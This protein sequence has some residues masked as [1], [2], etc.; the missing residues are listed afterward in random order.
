MEQADIHI[1][2]HYEYRD[3]PGDEG[4]QQVKVLEKVRSKWRVEWLDPNPGLVDYVKSAN[5]VVAWKDRGPFLGDEKR[6]RELQAACGRTWPG[7]DHPVS[8]AVDEVL[9]ATGEDLWVDNRGAFSG[10]PD[11]F[12]R[13]CVRARFTLPDEHVA[14]TDRRGMRHHTFDTALAVAQAFAAVEPRTVLD[15]IDVHERR[16]ETELREPGN[17]HLLPLVQRWRATW[18]L[19]RQWAGFDEAIAQRD[20]EIQRLRRIIDDLGW[21]LRRAGHED[22]ARTL[23]R[24][25]RGT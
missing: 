3:R 5:L 8:D 13:V 18:A 1:G 9:G 22:L 12:E 21:E 20:A 16:Y 24:R 25:R 23:D 10:A 17:A 6:S 7:H 15:Q 19:C 11:A 2:K 4:L 14:Y